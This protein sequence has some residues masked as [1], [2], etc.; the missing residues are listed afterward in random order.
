[1]P[2]KPHKWGYTFFVLSGASGF[3]YNLKF[4]TG[5]ENNSELRK[6]TEPDLSASVNVVRFERIIP[7]DLRHKLF[8]DNYHTTLQ[9]LVYRKKK[10]IIFRNY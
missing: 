9:L 5:Q 7:I 2:N 8:F 1:M 6:P 4:C 3:A 10:L